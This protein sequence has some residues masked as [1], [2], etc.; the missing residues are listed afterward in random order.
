MLCS[1][2][3]GLLLFLSFERQDFFVFVLAVEA[4]AFN[5]VKVL[6]Y[7]FVVKGTF[8][9]AAAADGLLC[10]LARI[11]AI[12]AC[13][14]S[15]LACNPFDSAEPPLLE[16]RLDENPENLETISFTL[17]PEAFDDKLTSD[18]GADSS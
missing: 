12:F 13:L 2:M 10:A 15:F 17:L 16:E 7:S 5:D 11:S 3:H 6:E 1:E 14:A 4:V 8:A 18:G 9:A